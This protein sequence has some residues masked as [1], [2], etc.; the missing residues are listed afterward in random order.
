MAYH[1]QGDK[2]QVV[3][4][5]AAKNK[6][7][8]KGVRIIMLQHILVDTWEFIRHVMK[9]GARVDAIIGKQYS[10]RSEI[11]EKMRA[12]GLQVYH[13]DYSHLQKDSKLLTNLLMKSLKEA[14]KN[15][16]KVIIHEVGG[17][18]VEVVKNLSRKWQP[19]F[20]GVVEDTTFGLNRYKA[21]EKS[22]RYPVL[23]VARSPLKEVEAVFVGEAIY[24]VVNAILRTHG[25]SMHGRKV[26]VVG[27][28]MISKNVANVFRRNYLHVI[29]YDKDPVKNLQAFLDGFEVLRD[30]KTLG[31]FDLIISSTGKSAIRYDDMKKMKSGVILVSGGSQDIEFDLPSLRRHTSRVISLSDDLKQYT[32]GKKRYIVMRDGTAVNFKID[33]IPDEIA[34][35]VYSEI[36]SAVL[37]LADNHG[38]LASGVNELPHSTRASIANTWL[39]KLMK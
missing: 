9:A 14:K 17:Y 16:E 21:I 8:L 4:F 30:K 28:G 15:H 29:V 1:L 34:D 22:L 3:K 31:D 33:S 19:Q 39:S 38:T 2:L 11:A 26:L 12:S 20:A 7:T 27:Y 13:A 35:L 18:F 32:I 25:V 23:H 6:R 24:L 5:I 36:L 37:C 10:T